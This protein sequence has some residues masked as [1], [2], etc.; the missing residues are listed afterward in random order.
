MYEKLNN[1]TL[2]IHRMCPISMMMLSSFL[3]TASG[4]AIAAV[5]QS[6]GGY[7]AAL[8][9]KALQQ[10]NTEAMCLDAVQRDG[11]AL[12][13]VRHQ[14]PAICLA[15][16]KQNWRAIAHCRHFTE[17]VVATAVLGDPSAILHIPPHLHFVAAWA[18][19]KAIFHLDVWADQDVV[20]AALRSAS[21]HEDHGL[22]TAILE[23]VP[24]STEMAHSLLQSNSGLFARFPESWRTV[25]AIATEAVRLWPANMKYVVHQTEAL[26][27]LACRRDPSMIRYIHEP[28]VALCADVVSRW[29]PALSYISS[30]LAN[31]F[32]VLVAAV[33]K[34]PDVLESAQSRVWDI[35]MA[36]RC[37]LLHPKSE[38]GQLLKHIWRSVRPAPKDLGPVE[39]PITL[40]EVPAETVCAFFRSPERR[41]GSWHFAGT[42]STLVDFA[43]T[44]YHESDCKKGVFVPLK[45]AVVPYKELVWFQTRS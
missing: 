27:T 13:E 37:V 15:A 38:L 40:D 32:D 5:Q 30:S 26:A 3:P 1:Q 36:A 11:L 31:T 41:G 39:D 6:K 12:R 20:M 45:N 24:V 33:K 23:R 10:P 44:R 43:V 35:W 17:P 25:E 18:N 8:K 19:P 16:V 42:A 28:S 9:A 29:P 14:T 2:P 4:T 7:A 34:R 22:Y 21:H